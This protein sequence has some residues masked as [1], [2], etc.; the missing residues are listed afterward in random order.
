MENNGEDGETPGLST[1]ANQTGRTSKFIE[2]SMNERSIGIASSWFQEGFSDSDKPLPFTPAIKHV[3]FSCTPG[4]ERGDDDQVREL[5]T[6]K[7]H[8]RRGLRKSI[9]NFN[10]QALSEKM[11]IFGGP[12]HDPAIEV[13]EKRKKVFQK[14]DGMGIDILN[15]RKRKADQAYAAQFGFKKQKFP[16]QSSGGAAPS[17]DVG[18]AGHQEH[19]RNEEQ[20]SHNSGTSRRSAATKSPSLPRK[21]S[22]RELEQEIADLRARLDAQHDL[23]HRRQLAAAT[24]THENAVRGKLVM[25]AP[26]KGRAKLDEDVPPM[27]PLPERGVLQVL[28]NSRGADLRQQKGECLRFVEEEEKQGKRSADGGQSWEWPEDVF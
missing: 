5:P 26:G 6:I 11:K 18:G 16:A 19:N 7:R 2:G 28:E 4:H 14:L 27:P 15:D 22:R 20:R 24:S 25:L 23:H 1:S 21:K 8:S 9:S 3:T 12:S 10:F 17:S 13:E